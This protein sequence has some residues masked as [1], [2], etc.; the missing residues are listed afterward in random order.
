VRD[1][2]IALV[3]AR[4][5]KDAAARDVDASLRLEQL[6]EVFGAEELD[7]GERARI[8]TALQM[9][10]LEPRPSLLEADPADPIRFTVEG[11]EAE[12]AAPAA[13]AVEAPAQ[14]RQEF[15]TVGE[16]FGRFRRKRRGG[17]QDEVI[18]AVEPEAL[19]PEPEPEPELAEPEGELPEP[20]LA[21]PELE[22]AGAPEEGASA[23]GHVDVESNGHSHLDLDDVA[24][25]P[26]DTAT[27][28]DF[29][30]SAET[31]D[32][33]DP[34]VEEELLY[35][36]EHEEGEYEDEAED[37]EPEPEPLL[38]PEP[39]AAEPV[40]M[41]PG[42]QEASVE[43]IA[44]LLL[45]LVAIPVVISSFAGWTFGLPF[46][47]LSV[48]AT[49]F[50]AG[51]RRGFFATLRASPAARTIFKTAVLVTAASAAVG[52]VI[53]SADT[54]GGGGSKGTSSPAPK[55]RANPPA[56][57]KKA[58]PPA[59]KH[60]NTATTPAA[61][62]RTPSTSTT[63]ASPPPDNSTKGLIRVPPRSSNNGQTQTS[64]TPAPQQQTP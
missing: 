22:E 27:P 28:A 46:V 24:L 8:Q 49:G 2:E 7:A 39:V 61:K 38:E 47:A 54:G 42:P 35:G 5:M 41:A 30:A 11:V 23:N 64:T 17:G 51:R 9:A 37:W 40:L 45:P 34:R 15:P 19:E 3:L 6:K 33:D 18:T 58:N 16:F 20:E 10:G 31:I 48:I 25:P 57:A 55:P 26:H 32:F 63:P 36:A 50:L 56:A 13:P 52:I 59:A 12:T 43:Q 60:T 4:E 1:V 62:P 29:G 21:E 53:A 14:E 44:A